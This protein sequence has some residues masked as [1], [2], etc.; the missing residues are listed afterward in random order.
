MI[1]VNHS[2]CL[3]LGGSFEP[4]YILTIN[5]LPVQVQPMTNKRNAALIQTFMAESIGVPADRGIVKFIP[6]VEENLATNGMTI[7]G[8]IE[9]LERQQA[10]ENGTTNVKRGRTKNSRKSSVFKAKSTMQLSHGSSK[11]DLALNPAI[12]SEVPLDGPLDSAV[13]INETAMDEEP[14]KSKMTNKKSEPMLSMFS[15]SSSAN[16]AQ[17]PITADRPVTPGI[18][19]RHSFLKVFRR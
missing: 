6:I 4:T 10:D 8:E 14:V 18:N 2:A 9:R 16:L 7:L 5:A 19:K 17:R 3:L 12:T 1:T 11:T 15:K 13:A